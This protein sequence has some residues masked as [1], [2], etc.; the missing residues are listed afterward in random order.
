MFTDVNLIFENG[1]CEAQY[2]GAQRQVLASIEAQGASILVHPQ[3]LYSLCLQVGLMP[4]AVDVA[5]V[6]PTP[7]FY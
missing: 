4:K 1:L 5:H 7:V 3:E 2:L 6:H